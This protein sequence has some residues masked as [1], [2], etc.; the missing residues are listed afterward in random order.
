M[1]PIQ[2]GQLDV[3]QLLITNALIPLAALMLLVG[4]LGGQFFRIGQGARELAHTA[5][6]RYTVNNLLSH[7]ARA[8][9]GQRGYLLTLRPAFKA[10]YRE[11]GDKVEVDLSKL[12]KLVADDPGQVSRVRR[13]RELNRAWHSNAQTEI[14]L[15]ESGDPRF[16]PVFTAGAGAALLDELLEQA[17]EFRAIEQQ[18]LDQ[19][20]VSQTDQFRLAVLLPG[21]VLGFGIVFFILVSRKQYR[22][23]DRTYADHLRLVETQKSV[24]SEQAEELQ[25][26]NE[27]LTAQTEELQ[28][29]NAEVIDRTAERDRVWDFSIDMLGIAGGDGYF[30]RLNPAWERTLGW[31]SQELMSEPF[32]QFVHPDDQEA[33]IVEYGRL[34]DGAT[35][36]VF[37]NR[38]RHKN[39][40]YRWVEWKCVP[41]A[42]EVY[43]AA[44]DVTDAKSSE[45][46]V[47]RH[48]ESLRVANRELEVLTVEAQEANRLKSEFLA[49]M[50][51]ELRTPL[52]SILGYSELVLKSK[53]A[54]LDERSRENLQVVKRNGKHLLALINDILDLAKVESG[55]ISLHLEP[56]DPQALVQGVSSVTQALA[57]E[58]G[59]ALLVTHEP[60]TASIVTD[61][62]K[63][64]QIVLNMVSNAIK[65]TNEGQVVIRVGPGTAQTWVVEV[66]DT[67][68]GI[69]PTDQLLVFEEFRQVDA[70]ATRVA[71]GTGLGLAIARKLARLL[72]GDLSLRSEPGA[73][74]T[75]TL[76]LPL[77]TPGE[78][79][80]SGAGNTRSVDCPPSIAPEGGKHV[81]V[82]ID[83]DPEMLYLLAESLRDSPYTLVPASSGETGLRLIRELRP[84]AITLD[85]LMPGMDGWELLR[86]VRLDPDLAETPV[87]IISFSDA[88]LHGYALGT[89]DY[90][91]KPVEQKDL[92]AALY[93]LDR[94]ALER[95]G[96]VLVIDDDADTRELYRQ[97]FADAGIRLVLATDGQDGIEVITRKLP[98]LVILDLM[99]PRMDGFEVMAWLRKHP[100]AMH[101][102]VVVVTSKEL[103]D[104]DRLALSEARQ[105]MQKGLL[106]N[107]QLATELRELLDASHQALQV[108]S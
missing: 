94:Q 10:P 85:I 53:K 86:E 3:R 62:T 108:S 22:R 2:Q 88:Q 101:V 56:L 15:R 25:A 41:V 106:S 19:I 61:S 21:I 87:L 75:F 1:K 84:Y 55:K 63:V 40:E 60:F 39:G 35:T 5:E 23:L 32:L 64:R 81:V 49:T 73:G 47:T 99:M 68:I 76:V 38:Y 16:L 70:S 83:D 12:E 58:K 24:L 74:S 57:R 51:H 71:G 34:L 13:I 97:V 107:S 78:L 82:A 33:T 69:A 92:L 48:N 20:E 26:A 27:E 11:A 36:L 80:V 93:R 46:A 72:G 91:S 45:V 7:L 50:S 4:L 29:M 79:P 42:N 52:N 17:L 9:S 30:K 77:V 98:E 90:L 59:I 89:T 28:A 37:Q 65:F 44:R 105:V 54:S 96:Y 66:E 100:A 6:V 14:R 8:E 104:E 18:R 103:T 95:G 43:C 67:G 102:P 31:T